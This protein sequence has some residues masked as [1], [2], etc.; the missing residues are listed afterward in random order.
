MSGPRG[1]D[2][3]DEDGHKTLSLSNQLNS[4]GLALRTEWDL[5][6]LGEK[7]KP[8]TNNAGILS[9][10]V[11]VKNKTPPVPVA[12]TEDDGLFCCVKLTLSAA[13]THKTTKL[14]VSRD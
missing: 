4:R 7:T 9:A 13:Q 3:P 12:L 1:R 8:Q 10:S 2:V 6:E 14:R 5:A 11:R